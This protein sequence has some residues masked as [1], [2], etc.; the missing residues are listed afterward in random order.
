MPSMMHTIIAS[1]FIVDY[2]SEGTLVCVA[3]SR[4]V[5]VMVVELTVYST[6][7]VIKLFVHTLVFLQTTLFFD[8]RFVMS[9]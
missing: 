3:A 5:E 8:S 9:L 4:V 7:N 1:I 6:A 2:T